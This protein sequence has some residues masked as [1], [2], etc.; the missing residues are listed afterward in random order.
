[1]K[2]LFACCLSLVAAGALAH[3]ATPSAPGVKSDPVA[4]LPSEAEMWSL[5]DA[6]REK[7][8]TRE[9]LSLNGLWAFKVDN[10][11]ASFDRAPQAASMDCYFKVP[12]GWPSCKADARDGMAIY[13]KTGAD[14]AGAAV[15]SIDS[16]WYAR[17]VKVPESWR[18]RDIVV[19]FQWIPTIALV[20]VDGKKSG[21]VFFPGGEVSLGD[22]APGEHEIAFFTSAKLAETMVTAFDA[23]DTARSFTKKRAS[24]AQS[25]SS[26]A[27]KPFARCRMA[28]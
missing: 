19:G 6:G 12:G 24:F 2:E 20:Y 25:T 9:K 8:A 4:K 18:G 1:M 26:F 14:A 15:K 16:A 7:T 10:A 28:S 27:V 11:A 17:R 21:E 13:T 3:K 22:L 5:A 23:P